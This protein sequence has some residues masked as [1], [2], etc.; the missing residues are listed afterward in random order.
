MNS[1]GGTLVVGIDDNGNSLG[2]EKD[3]ETFSDRKQGIKDVQDQGPLNITRSNILV[4]LGASHNR[5]ILTI[6][7]FYN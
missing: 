3:Y 1:D 2:L 7:R 5:I 4:Y 6:V